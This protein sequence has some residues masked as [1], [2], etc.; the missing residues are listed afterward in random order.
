MAVGE[1]RSILC[2]GADCGKEGV[3]G[4]DNS[5][6]MGWQ[7]KN[8]KPYCPICWANPHGV[9]AAGVHTVNIL[10][11]STTEFNVMC[12]NKDCNFNVTKPTRDAAKTASYRHLMDLLPDRG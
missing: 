12:T 5:L 4:L 3:L 7:V 9:N 10:P 1:L 11:I 8:A 6:P 2:A